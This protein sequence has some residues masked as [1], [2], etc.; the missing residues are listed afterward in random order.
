MILCHIV[1]VWGVSALGGSAGQGA[2]GLTLPDKALTPEHGTSWR[3]VP[4][5][6][7]CS[8]ML[9]HMP[10]SPYLGHRGRCLA[11]LGWSR[12][13]V[14]MAVILLNHQVCSKDSSKDSGT[15]AG[16]P[17]LPPSRGKAQ[18]PWEVMLRELVA[19]PSPRPMLWNL[20]QT[21]HSFDHSFIH[22]RWMGP[23]RSLPVSGRAFSTVGGASGQVQLEGLQR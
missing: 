23:R 10:V 21:T 14:A 17:G 8:P 4:L 15:S 22:P 5:P 11:P 18:T 7:P 19:L 12:L 13:T 1:A 16:A 20:L 2:H 9:S 6:E 3:V